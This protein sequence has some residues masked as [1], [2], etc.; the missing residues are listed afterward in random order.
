MRPVASE[1]VESVLGADS[2]VLK[3]MD[4]AKFVLKAA[5]FCCLVAL[6]NSADRFGKFN[7]SL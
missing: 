5:V 2:E 4:V 3:K 6:G 7:S 1:V